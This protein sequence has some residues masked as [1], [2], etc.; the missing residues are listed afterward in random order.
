MILSLPSQAGFWG[1][2]AEFTNFLFLYP[3]AYIY[4]T[5]EIQVRY[6]EIQ[7]EVIQCHRLL[8]QRLTTSPPLARTAYTR[9]YLRFI[10]RFMISPKI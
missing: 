6:S 10:V 1:Q 9:S 4:A 5:E 8:F 2:A 7:L 3:S